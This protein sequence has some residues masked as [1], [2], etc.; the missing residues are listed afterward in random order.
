MYIYIYIYKTV[1]NTK[2]LSDVYVV[3]GKRQIKYKFIPISLFR[4][5][6]LIFKIPR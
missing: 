6:P 5:C 1:L 4:G 2:K 3:G